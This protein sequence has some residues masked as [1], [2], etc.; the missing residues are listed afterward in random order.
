MPEWPTDLLEQ[1]DDG[2]TL[3]AP[4]VGKVECIMLF[5][6]TGDRVQT[7]RLSRCAFVPL[8]KGVG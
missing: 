3:I 8:V 5:H 1:L 7:C 2:G 4:M 6:K